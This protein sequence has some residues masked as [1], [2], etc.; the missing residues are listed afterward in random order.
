MV[1]NAQSLD[2]AHAQM[3][4]IVEVSPRD[5]LQ[6]EPVSFD[7]G[8]KINLI[9]RAVAAGLE[10]IEVASFVNPKIV[11]QMADAEAV[12][13]GLS[14]GSRSGAIG[15]VLNERGMDRAIASGIGEVNYVVVVTETFSKANQGV[16]VDE[17]IAMLRAVSKRCRHAGIR[18]SVTL[19]AAFGCPFE[20]EVTQDR[21]GM[22]VERI[23]GFGAD[24]I[25]LADTVGAAVPP[26]VSDR[27]GLLRSIVGPKID[28]R[29]HFHNTRNVGLAN[30]YAAL[31]EGVRIFDGSIG[32]IGGCPFAPK[33]TGNVPTEDLVFMFERSGFD[34]GVNLEAVIDI[35]NFLSSRMDRVLPGLV[36]RAGNFPRN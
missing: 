4:S 33:S 7:T 17:N 24:E 23:A 6:N 3:V 20:G 25:A 16:S 30:A 8:D 22:I 5:G 11:P 21:L 26:M 36:S 14:S 28:L 27:I 2:S 12:I 31:L 18:L 13:A 9:E 35:A 29:V 34:T 1:L 10:R 32:G 15:L 19:S